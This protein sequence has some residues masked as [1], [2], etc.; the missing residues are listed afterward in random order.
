MWF[1]GTWHSLR[2]TTIMEDRNGKGKTIAQMLSKSI[3]ETVD[4]NAHLLTILDLQARILAKLESRDHD[5]VV[6]EINEML[7]ERRR[8][9]LTE[10]DRWAGGARNVFGEDE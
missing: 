6:S 3:L 2:N 4:N 9:A 5:E 8:T 10:I 7:K 1:A